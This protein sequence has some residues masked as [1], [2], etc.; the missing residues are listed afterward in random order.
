MVLPLSFMG[1]VRANFSYQLS[2]SQENDRRTSV[3][4]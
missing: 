3:A 1:L 4:R 2:V